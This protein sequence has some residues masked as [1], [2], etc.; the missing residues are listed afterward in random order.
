MN[1]VIEGCDGTGKSTLAKHICD[2]FGLRYWHESQPRSYDE[3]VSMLS[4]G[5]TVFDRFCFGQF[6]YNRPEDRKLSEAELNKLLTEVFPATNTLLIYVDCSTEEIFNR[7]IARGEA[8]KKDAIE[9]EKWIKNIRGTYKE[10]L[11]KIG[12]PYV[13]V[14]GGFGLCI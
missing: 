5:G 7:M 12:C 14:N 8:Q 1:I 3:Y 13:Q 11:N 10:Y 9:A 4:C 2:R 6:V